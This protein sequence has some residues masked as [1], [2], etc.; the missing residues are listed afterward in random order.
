VTWR[1]LASTAVELAAG[2]LLLSSVLAAVAGG[3]WPI[4]LL[5]HFRLQGLVAALL[6]GMGA[7]GLRRWIALDLCA[8][9]C[10]TQMIHV[11][12]ALGGEP[13]AAPDGA[14][15]VRVLLLNVHTES[16]TYARVAALIDDVDADVV[17]LVEVDRRWL[18]ALAPALGRYDARVEHPRD[19]NFG[20]AIYTRGELRGAFE[21]L[22]S[23]RPSLV[24]E[25]AGA[26]WILTHPPPPIRRAMFEAQLQQIDAVADR[27]RGLDGPVIVL[28]DLNATPWSRPFERLIA[29]SGLV[30][31]RAGFGVQASFPAGSSVLRIPIDHVLVTPGVGVRARWIARDVGSDH[32]P[33]VVELAIPPDDRHRDHAEEHRE[34]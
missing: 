18:E 31:T 6:V 20:L 14:V 4:G 5:E 11:A 22:G 7:A 24:V 30:D 13:L 29:R 16:T 27:A 2:G 15:P 23:D 19:D 9:A 34:P 12:P 10:A 3:T 33:V 1:R 28:G 26:T 32:L 25:H 21:E 8:F 17:A